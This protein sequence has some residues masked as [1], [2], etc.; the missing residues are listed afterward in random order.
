MPESVHLYWG[1][2]PLAV[3]VTGE[4]YSPGASWPV[5]ERCVCVS[6]PQMV[7]GNQGY[8]SSKKSVT[9]GVGLSVAPSRSILPTHRGLDH[10]MA[11]GHSL[12]TISEVPR[13]EMGKG[14]GVITR[15]IVV[16]TTLPHNPC[17]SRFSPYLCLF[18]IYVYHCL[19]AFPTP[20]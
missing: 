1:R 19:S 3:G 15:L 4:K 14:T 18:P 16:A 13:G 8:S 10:I 5:G 9:S 17:L 6:A 11:K 20:P 2:S 7:V 12:A